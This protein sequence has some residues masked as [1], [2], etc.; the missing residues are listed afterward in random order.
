MRWISYWVSEKDKGQTDALIKGFD[1][2][3]G[4]I[5]AWLNSDDMYLPD[6]LLTIG[7]HFIQN[8]KCDLIYGN[9][10]IINEKDEI[11]SEKQK[12]LNG[13][14]KC[15]SGEIN[16]DSLKLWNTVNQPAT[17]FTRRVYELVGKIDSAL[18][19]C[20]DYELWIKIFKQNYNIQYVND[21]FAI[22]RIHDESKTG[23]SELTFNIDNLVI[24]VRH[25]TIKEIKRNSCIVCYS[26]AKLLKT[27]KKAKVQYYLQKVL[28]KINV[29]E[30]QYI[31][32]QKIIEHEL[33]N[34]IFRYCIEQYGESVIE[35]RFWS[36]IKNILIAFYMKPLYL[37]PYSFKK[38]IC[39]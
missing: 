27:N 17:F 24:S 1:K 18:H 11:N 32:D 3:S 26:A 22:F 2:T 28:K 19:Y 10:Y 36:A 8:K 15:I 16:L 13:I 35:K 38:I 25:L 23:Q 37:M 20:M 33:R 21:Y 9:L 5:L 7:R 34:G 30:I 31:I 6:S 12:N 14:V 4:E 29:A 39:K